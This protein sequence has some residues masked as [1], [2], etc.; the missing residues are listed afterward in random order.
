MV[1]TNPFNFIFLQRDTRQACQRNDSNAREE[2]A[3]GDVLQF[4]ES[5]RE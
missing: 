3:L 4:K 1:S 2:P 5:E